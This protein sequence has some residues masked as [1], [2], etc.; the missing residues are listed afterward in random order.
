MLSFL[1]LKNEVVRIWDLEISAS[2]R[3]INRDFT[4]MLESLV[5]LGELDE[6]VNSLHEKAEAM[7]EEL[8]N[9]GKV[10]TLNYWSVHEQGDNDSTEDAE[11]FVSLLNDVDPLCYWLYDTFLSNDPHLRLVVL[12]FVPLLVGL[13]LSRLHSPEPPSLAGFEALLFALYATET[14]SRNGKPIVIT[15][16]DLNHPSIYHAPLRKPQSQ[17][18]SQSSPSLELISLPLEPQLAVKSTKHP[19]IFVG[20]DCPCRNDLDQTLDFDNLL[21][22]AQRIPLPW[23]ILQPS[24]RI[25]SHCLLGPLN[26]PPPPPPPPDVKDADSSSSS[27]TSTPAPPMMSDMPRTVRHD[28]GAGEPP[29]EQRIPQE[30]GPVNGAILTMQGEQD[31]GSEGHDHEGAGGGSLAKKATY[32][33][34]VLVAVLG[35]AIIDYIEAIIDYDLCIIDYAL[36]TFLLHACRKSRRHYCLF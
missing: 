11:V 14:K 5:K 27:A 15:I 36:P 33:V 30:E 25:L 10:T 34:S 17:S 23:E 22:Q 2:K 3:R 20:A 29:G 6:A 4:T 13:Y 16:P 24:L 1:E 8:Q 35:A 26:P 32:M 9:S 18:Q 19:T 21:P 7:L 12:T 31:E 28:S